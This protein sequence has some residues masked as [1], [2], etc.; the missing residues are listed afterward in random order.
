MIKKYGLLLSAFLAGAFFGS[1]VKRMWYERG[2]T[3]AQ[4]DNI[5]KASAAFD[6]V[7]QAIKTDKSCAITVDSGVVT[8]DSIQ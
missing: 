5:Q 8:V 3:P 7:I 6:M 1:P 2:A 4:K